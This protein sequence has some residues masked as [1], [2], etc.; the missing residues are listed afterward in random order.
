MINLANKSNK[1]NF[2]EEEKAFNQLV[3]GFTVSL[4]TF[5]SI[6]VCAYSGLI[7]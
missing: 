5:V 6:V 3:I 4:V 7:S 2:K 1:V